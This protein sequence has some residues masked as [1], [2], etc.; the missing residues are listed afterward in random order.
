MSLSKEDHKRIADAIRAAEAKT[1]G[2]IVCVLT[3]T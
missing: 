2:E 1:T 3:Q